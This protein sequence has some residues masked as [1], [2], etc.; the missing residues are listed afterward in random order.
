MNRSAERLC[1]PEIPEDMFVEAV[2]AVVD[3]CKDK[4]IPI[5]I[6]VNGGSLDKRLLESTAI[7]PRKR[8]WRALSSIWNCW[9]STVSM[10]P[11]FP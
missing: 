11:A 10:I 6:G 8:W 7:P 4:K 2:K 3:I 9:K 1:L 5:R